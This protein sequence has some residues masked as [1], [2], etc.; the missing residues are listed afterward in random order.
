MLTRLA[1]CRPAAAA[2]ALAVGLAA[3]AS[4]YDDGR[5]LTPAQQ[6][7]RRQNE[8]FNETIATGAVV[9]ALTLA[10]LGALLAGE[11]DR[12]TGAVI[13]A[14]AGA[15]VGA[16]A[17]HYLATRN[18]RYASREQAAMARIEAAERE[19]AEFAK[20]ARAAE[21]VA[22][23]NRARLRQLEAQ[24]TRGQATAGQLAAQQRA[25]QQDLA[26]MEG[27]I[28]NAR[29]AGGRVAPAHGGRRTRTARGAC[30][31]PEGM[32][33][34]LLAAALLAAA[35]G[36]AGPARERGF[37][38]GLSAAASGEDER[39]A[40][41]LEAEAGRAEAQ[42]L[43]ARARAIAAERQREVSAAE[44]RDAERRLAALQ[45]RIEGMRR[46]F[47][48]LQ[49]ARGAHD[50]GQGA[51]LGQRIETLERERQAATAAPDA[52]TAARLERQAGEIA[53][54]LEAYRRL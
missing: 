39:R 32:R 1:R 9:G 11:R 26:L 33:H 31:E 2:L 10:I 13:G 51:A 4:T 29:K 27:A 14:T 17:G 34:A 43:Q 45:T 38:G 54:A 46:E 36:P 5:P 52:A 30:A 37:F 7:L 40:Q 35:C 20:T 8:R 16:A 23:E 48:A 42:A 21:Q 22:A 24:V 15:M 49:A 50:A 47:A 3:C 6:E 12:G 44:L 25:A 19:A 41:A 28:G 18:E 53:R